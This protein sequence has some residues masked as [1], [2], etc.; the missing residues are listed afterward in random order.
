MK[1]LNTKNFVQELKS[2]GYTESRNSGSH[3]IFTK[4]GGK[5]N[6]SFPAGREISSGVARDL[7]KR[8]ELNNRG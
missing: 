5:F 8:I 4:A 3:R 7:L 2:L 1:P 6:I